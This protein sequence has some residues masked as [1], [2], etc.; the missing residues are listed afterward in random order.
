[1]FQEN[2]QK[3]KCEWQQGSDIKILVF[4]ISN[5]LSSTKIKKYVFLMSL[6]DVFWSKILYAVAI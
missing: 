1:M 5:F 6:F 2:S 4:K 3:Y